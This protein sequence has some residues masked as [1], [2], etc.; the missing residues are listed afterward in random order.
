MYPNLYFLFRELFGTEL[1]FLKAIGSFGFFMALGF[2]PGAWLWTRELKYKEKKGELTYITK[3]VVTGGGVNTSSIVLHFMLGFVAGFKLIG[4]VVYQSTLHNNYFFSLQGSYAGAFICAFT[5]AAFTFYEGYSTKK[6]KP[7][8]ETVRVYPHEYVSQGVIVSAVAGVAG[9]KFFGLL[10][11]WSDFM[12]HPADQLFS[13]EGYTFLGGFIVAS[14]AMWVYYYKFGI[15]RVRM[16]DA[17][18][19]VLMLCYA[20]GRIGCHIAGDGD[21]GINNPKPNPLAWLPDWLWSYDYPHNIIRKG[22]YMQDCSTWDDFCYKLAVPV[23]PTPL[24]ELLLGLI[25]VAILLSALRKEKVAG[26]VSAYCFMLM[27]IERFFI[28]KI[29]VDVRY[30]FG[31]LHPTQAEI[32]SVGCFCFGICLYFIAPKLKVNRKWAHSKFSL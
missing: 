18:A 29:R 32:L 26:R 30:S 15:L 10:E 6:E 8:A 12:R 3:K 13:S 5:W 21:W 27:G 1:P 17:L 4:L 23:Y 28:E 16:A 14:V 25:I 22:I 19:P 2:I 7:Q 24:Y 9:A 20:L 11:N 31:G